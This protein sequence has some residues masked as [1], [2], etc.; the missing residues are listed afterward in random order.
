[1]KNALKKKTPKGLWNIITAEKHLMPTKS[2][3]QKSSNLQTLNISLIILVRALGR[4]PAADLWLLKKQE[5][6]GNLWSED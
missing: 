2:L 6:V 3:R 1:M 5:I 4:Y